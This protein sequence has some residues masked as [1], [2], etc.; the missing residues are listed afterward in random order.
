MSGDANV[1][2]EER[3]LNFEIEKHA[4]ERWWHEDELIHQRTTW[5]LTAQG[6]LGAA[7][8]FVKYRIAELAFRIPGEKPEFD[9]A[10]YIETLG[11]FAAA[12]VAIGVLSA[13][14]TFVGILAAKKAQGRL[15]EIYGTHMGISPRTTSLGHA[16]S[17][18]TPV[19]CVVAWLVA[20][21]LF[22]R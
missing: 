4:R 10:H 1:S 22:R 7:F 12:L 5:L 15:R 2:I 20:Y 21:W 17:L 3:K 6:V 13:L 14:V 16:V 9:Y 19:L 11:R 18:S 8:G